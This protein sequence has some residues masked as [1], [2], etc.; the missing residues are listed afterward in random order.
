VKIPVKPL[1]AAFVLCIAAQPVA[2]AQSGSAPNSPPG[3]T[4]SW[5]LELSGKYG[6]CTGP[7][8]IGPPND[9]SG[10]DWTATYAMT[11]DG[12]A[13]T[14]R[15]RFD[16]RYGAGGNYHFTGSGE[17]PDIFDLRWTQ[18]GKALAGSGSFANEPLSAFQ[19][20]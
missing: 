19:H 5:V 14:G 20:K 9:A 4:G 15:Q 12:N 2:F 3:I 13:G 11:C 10:A 6:K 1:I 16:I 18:D 7:V 8:N 17:Y